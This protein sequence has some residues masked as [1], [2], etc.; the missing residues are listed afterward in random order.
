MP[1]GL[2]SRSGT[3]SRSR[4]VSRGDDSDGSRSPLSSSIPKT[5]VDKV[6]ERPS[7]GEVEGTL[8]K[9]MRSADAAPDEVRHTGDVAGARNDGR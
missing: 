1:D 4:S 6:D 2:R 7:H 3:V 5:V 8:A 9:E